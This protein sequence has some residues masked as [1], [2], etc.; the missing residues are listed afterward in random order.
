MRP[1]PENC[2]VCGSCVIL[3]RFA[4]ADW[5]CFSCGHTVNCDV[6]KAKSNYAIR[7]RVQ[8][9][10]DIKDIMALEADRTYLDPQNDWGKYEKLR[11]QLKKLEELND[12]TKKP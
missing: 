9:I 6:E 4:E 8:D 7:Q 5:Y 10:K 1:K 12:E 2:P 3:S 11:K